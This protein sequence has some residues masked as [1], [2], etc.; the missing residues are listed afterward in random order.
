[1]HAFTQ[2]ILVPGCIPAHV[3]VSHSRRRVRKALSRFWFFAG[4]RATI[5]KSFIGV[6]AARRQLLF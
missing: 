4:V 2:F 3:C 1:M 5:V 6:I